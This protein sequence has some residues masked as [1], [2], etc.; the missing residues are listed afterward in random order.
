MAETTALGELDDRR[1]R[2]A[3]LP[4]RLASVGRV[5]LHGDEV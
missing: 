2:P 1:L 3:D 4:Q 5:P